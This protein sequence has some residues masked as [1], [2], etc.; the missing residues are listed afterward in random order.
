MNHPSSFSFIWSWAG[1]YKGV[2]VC[3]VRVWSLYTTRTC[4]CVELLPV[5]ALLPLLEM[6]PLTD[7]QAYFTGL[8]AET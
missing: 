5:E 1:G 6:N 2:C 4:T 7:K 3:L 8:L